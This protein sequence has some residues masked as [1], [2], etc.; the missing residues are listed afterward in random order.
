MPLEFGVSIL[1]EIDFRVCDNVLRQF[2]YRFLLDVSPIV[3]N[4]IVARGDDCK[5][6]Q[7]F[8]HVSN[9]YCLSGLHNALIWQTDIIA[10]LKA[11]NQFRNAVAEIWHRQ[12]F[13]GV[14][15]AFLKTSLNGLTVQTNLSKCCLHATNEIT[16]S[17]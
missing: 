2:V 4:A 5:L 13:T 15:L 9:C 12:D 14:N 8:R 1:N 10:I 16:H 17:A 6:D 3:R 11:Q 7:W